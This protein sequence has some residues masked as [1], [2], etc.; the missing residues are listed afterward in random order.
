MEEVKQ[1]STYSY[2]ISYVSISL[3][4]EGVSIKIHSIATIKFIQ[5]QIYNYCV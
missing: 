3:I 1:F 4:L 5:I 2:S